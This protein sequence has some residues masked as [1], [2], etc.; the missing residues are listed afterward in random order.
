M[1]EIIV[2]R[3]MTPKREKK[4]RTQ[5]H[6]YLSSA[7]KEAI[8]KL[9]LSQGR[10]ATQLILFAVKEYMASGKNWKRSF[11]PEK[12]DRALVA[13]T[14]PPEDKAAIVAYAAERQMLPIELFREAIADRLSR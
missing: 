14:I 9:A 3:K 5:T 11:P 1:E 10:R 7:D 6:L 2:G 4:Q 12:A 8:T 13:M